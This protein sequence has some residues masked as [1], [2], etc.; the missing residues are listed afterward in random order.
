MKRFIYFICANLL[1]FIPSCRCCPPRERKKKKEK[2][3]PTTRK[4]T[5]DHSKLWERL[6]FEAVFR[7][8]IQSSD[9]MVILNAR[10]RLQLDMRDWPI[11][12]NSDWIFYW[13]DEEEEEEGKKKR[14]CLSRDNSEQSRVSLECLKHL[15][16]GLNRFK[17]LL[18]PSL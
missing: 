17:S 8:V 10:D 9:W 11:S 13:K 3:E 14:L 16:E 4:I 18:K 2:K 6:C 12:W 1:S 7:N 5:N 15:E